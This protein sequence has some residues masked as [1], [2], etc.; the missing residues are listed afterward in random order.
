M[1]E[2]DK[3]LDTY[4]SVENG[5]NVDA[6]C[7]K[8]NLATFAIKRR[9]L[10]STA[11]ATETAYQTIFET[12]IPW[13]EFF[14]GGLQTGFDLTKTS[15]MQSALLFILS[16]SFIEFEIGLNKFESSNLINKT[17]NLKVQTISRIISTF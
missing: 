7:A 5:N 2:F 4:V 8:L 9:K 17:L 6:V 3:L 10:T 15:R 1:G 16:F 11:T 12:N 14:H 13:G